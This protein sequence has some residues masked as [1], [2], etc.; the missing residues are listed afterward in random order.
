MFK[1]KTLIF[2]A[3][4]L[5]LMLYGVLMLCTNNPWPQKYTDIPKTIYI[6]ISS[7]MK[8]LDPMG[9]GY[10]HEAEVVNQTIESF[11]TY[12]YLKRPFELIPQLAEEIPTLEYYDHNGK[13]IENDDPPH[14]DVERMV[15]TIKIKKGIKYQPHP[16]FARN[17]AGDL[18]YHSLSRADCA[19]IYTPNEFPV[20]GTK[21]LTAED[22]AVQ[23]RRLCD[24]RYSTVHY[25]TFTNYIV[26]MKECSD[27]IA[28]AVADELAKTP[29]RNADLEPVVIDYLKIPL[30]GVEV[31]DSYTIRYY[32]KQK[33][34]QMLYWMAMPVF[35]PCPQDVVNFYA[36]PALIENTIQLKNW[37]VGTGPFFLTEYDATQRMVFQKNPNFRDEFY[38]SEGEPSD[39]EAGLL[40]AAGQ[41]LP[42]VDQLVFNIEREAISSWGKFMQGYYENSAIS[43]DMFDKAINTGDNGEMSLSP[44]M[45]RKNIE[46]Y[47]ATSM[48]VFYFAFNMQDPVVGGYSEEQCKL[49]QAISIALDYNQFLNL[50]LNGRGLVAQSIL[51]PAIFG[52]KEGAESTNPY[53]DKWNPLSQKNERLPIEHARKLMAEAGYPNGRG[54]DNRPLSITLQHA[55]GGNA[56][57]KAQFQWMRGRLSLLGIDL[58]EDASDINRLRDKH[59][60]GQ[61]QVCTSGWAGDYPDPE[62]F[63]FLFYSPQGKV[64]HSGQNLVNYESKVFDDYFKQFESMKNCPKRFEL[65]QKATSVLQ[66][67]APICFGFNQY[68][69]ALMHGWSKN[70]KPHPLIY[71]YIYRDVDAPTRD[72][73]RLAWNE[74]QTTPVLIAW[75]ILLLIFMPPLCVI[76]YRAQKAEEENMLEFDNS[77]SEKGA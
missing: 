45:L 65:I 54:A 36:Q 5:T 67:D 57:Y 25:S 11:F 4:V 18:L 74:P 68:T 28:K 30:L 1:V 38:P 53:T 58:K 62:N 63:F 75:G 56:S 46:M 10:T 72:S 48:T 9:V 42:L 71:P 66:H 21:E 27:A 52:S 20:L 31:V 55:Q 22:F 17:E 59:A 69:F 3:I 34:P 7:E 24:A 32:C 61:W 8:T 39:K 44:E 16:A 43:N 64:N 77:E 40:N 35:S 26:G 37:P 33:Y 73:A 49:R 19:G 6:P 76:A 14:D 15:I 70:Y 12:H 23:A 41:K 2:S 29:G 47:S 50:F 13:R 51:P 60:K